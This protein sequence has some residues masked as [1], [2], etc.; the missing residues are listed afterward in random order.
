MHATLP[1]PVLL[2]TIDVG[3]TKQR[4]ILPAARRMLAPGGRVISLIK[5]HYESP[6]NLL[7]KGI[8]PAD[9]LDEVIR[10]GQARH[11]RGGDL[12]CWG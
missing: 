11:S 12:S 4:H 10:D 1:E 3:W 7:R 8:L 9:R 5:P 6:P 2:V